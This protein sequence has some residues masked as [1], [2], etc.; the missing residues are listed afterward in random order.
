MRLNH[1][2]KQNSHGGAEQGS[3]LIPVL[4]VLLIITVLGLM[5]MR[6]GLVNLNI[7]TNA[8]VRQLLV[9]S[10]DAPLNQYATLDVS[11]PSNVSMATVLGAALDASN[12]GREF[13]FCY[14]ST[15]SQ[16]FGLMYN[17]NTIQANP[18]ATAGTN[19]STVIDSSGSGFCDP[20]ADFSSG[21]KAVV[22]QVSVLQPTDESTAA[23][24]SYLARDSSV[25]GGDAAPRGYTQKQRFRVISTS[26]LPGMA[27]GAISTSSAS[28]NCLQGRISD[29][30]DPANAG[31]ETVTDCLA[32]NGVPVNT[33]V[34]EYGLTSS[35]TQTT[36][37]N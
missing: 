24:G 14:K 9:Q 3:A 36:D 31:L 27:T 22:T 26:F 28:T 33:Q 37:I 30:S 8:Q 25:G 32:R 6:Q 23:A 35:L 7:S 11:Q 18:S 1:H 4:F 5:A 12:L 13:V 21:R 34:Q 16:K 29:N 15:S 2:L 20:T 17:A 10:A 19:T